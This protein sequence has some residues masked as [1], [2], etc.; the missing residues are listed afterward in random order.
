MTDAEMRNFAERKLRQLQITPVLS[1]DKY[2]FTAW[3]NS[4]TDDVLRGETKEH[5]KH[6]APDSFSFPAGESQYTSTDLHRRHLQEA[7]SS[8]S[9][10]LNY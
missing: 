8:S 7:A 6:D 1:R 10:G 4:I 2:A 5:L 9:I 3:M